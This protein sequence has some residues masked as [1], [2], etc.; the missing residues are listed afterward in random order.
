MNNNDGSI[1]LFKMVSICGL[2]ICAALLLCSP[3]YSS[4]RIPIML[5]G[6]AC[7]INW[8]TSVLPIKNPLQNVMF[9]HHYERTRRV[10]ANICGILALVA[11]W[12]AFKR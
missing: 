10:V 4:M 1:R 12:V 3:M 2:L 6:L 9:G 5:G 8:I 7:L 11:A